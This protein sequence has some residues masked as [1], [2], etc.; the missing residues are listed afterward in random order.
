MRSAQEP[1]YN[2]FVLA[3]LL[4]SIEKMGYTHRGFGVMI[5]DAIHCSR[6]DVSCILSGQKR[7]T[8]HFLHSYCAAFGISETWLIEGEGDI[9]VNKPVSSIPAGIEVAAPGR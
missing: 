8:Y 3:R 9:F 7:L 2:N 5:A 6:K 4:I 1:V